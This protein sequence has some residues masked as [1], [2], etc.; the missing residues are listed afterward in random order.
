MNTF[1]IGFNMKTNKPKI[2]VLLILLT[3]LMIDIFS[4]TPRSAVP[5]KKDSETSAKEMKRTIV[6]QKLIRIQ[7]EFKRFK[8]RF[9]ESKYDGL[10]K[11]MR[12]LE[13]DIFSIDD[14]VNRID[15]RQERYAEQNTNFINNK[16]AELDEQL[17]RLRGKI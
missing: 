4:S 11:E 13:G 1:V 17:S 7:N 9:I 14:L 6:Q 5:Q 3:W 10:S 12:Q 15:P 2:I 16:L 8:L